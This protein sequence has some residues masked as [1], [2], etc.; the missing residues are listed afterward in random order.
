MISLDDARVELWVPAEE[1]DRICREQ[2]A[3]VFPRSKQASILMLW[4][5]LLDHA[6]ST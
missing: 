5:K 4:C 6:V 1:Y 3:E 2:L